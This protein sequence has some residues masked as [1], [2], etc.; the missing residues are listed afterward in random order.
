MLSR[1]LC[2]GT[3]ASDV[4]SD[5][6]YACLLKYMNICTV[7]AFNWELGSGTAL[8]FLGPNAGTLVPN[9]MQM[10]FFFSYKRAF[11]KLIKKKKKTR[12]C[13]TRVWI[14]RRALRF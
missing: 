14:I 9:G 8:L 6:N 12:S 5:V 13:P 7:P 4:I 10:N 2:T 1:A 11:I 3:S